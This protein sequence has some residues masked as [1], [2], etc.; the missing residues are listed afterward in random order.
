MKAAEVPDVGIA[1]I[2]LDHVRSKRLTGSTLLV[3][4]S[5][6]GIDSGRAAGGHVAGEKGSSE[7]RHC[8]RT[9]GNRINGAHSIKQ[10]V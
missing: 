3:A 8:H 10:A 6:H 7:Q 9:Q 4:Q 2:N 1:I 5:Y